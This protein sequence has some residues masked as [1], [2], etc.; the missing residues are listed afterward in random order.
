MSKL[1]IILPLCQIVL[2]ALL[3]LVFLYDV[4]AR[5]HDSPGLYPG[6]ILLLSI[7]LPVSVPLKL[8]L[9]GRLPPLWF[10]TVF[11][12]MVGVLWYGVASCILVYLQRQGVFPPDRAWLRVFADVLLVAM[13]VFLLWAIAEELIHY[14][15]MLSPS[16]LGGWLW[17]TPICMSVLLWSVGSVLVFGYDLRNC[18]RQYYKESA[19]RTGTS[20]T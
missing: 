7:N 18:V 11:V 20:P 3:L 16:H 19:N 1:R 15:F 14:P 8:L 4:A 5:H 13:G 10:S 2:A 12:A 6:F 17:F 9:Y